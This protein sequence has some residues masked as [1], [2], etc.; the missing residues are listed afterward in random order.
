MNTVHRP[1]PFTLPSEPVD[2]H[3]V[4][5]FHVE[6]QVD[7]AIVTQ[8]TA[9]YHVDTPHAGGDAF[10][11]VWRIFTNGLPCGRTDDGWS[12]VVEHRFN[13]AYW[14]DCR[15]TRAEANDLA[16]EHLRAC[17][18]SHVREIAELDEAL[19][20]LAPPAP[21]L[22]ELGQARLDYENAEQALRETRAIRAKVE[23]EEHTAFQRRREAHLK[24]ERAE[25][26]AG[27]LIPVRPDQPRSSDIMRC[28]HCRHGVSH[29]WGFCAEAPRDVR[30]KYKTGTC[31][32]PGDAGACEADPGFP[33]EC[34]RVR[35]VDNG[36]ADC[37]E[38]GWLS[39][40]EVERRYPVVDDEL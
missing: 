34:N 8:H 37:G 6:R 27:L 4:K 21:V 35:R 12:A 28:K 39:I 9:R 23:I 2:Q 13:Q 33:L 38:D 15:A 36:R 20:K 26:V 19:T 3:D 5:W 25:R 32:G 18:A 10:V 14:D 30:A 16:S 24:L 22:D 40:A 31:P 29:G 11:N 7:R 17:R 1:P